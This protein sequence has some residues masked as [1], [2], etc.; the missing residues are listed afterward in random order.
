M[1]YNDYNFFSGHYQSGGFDFG[2]NAVDRIFG[3]IN[4]TINGVKDVISNIT[5]DGSRRNN[6]GYGYGYNPYQNQY[7]YPYQGYG[8]QQN[9]NG[10]VGYGWGDIPASAF[11]NNA[12]TYGGYPGIWNTMY[13]NGGNIR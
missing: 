2:P 4:S 5:D 13:G 1:N 7:S 6:Q 11:M 9:P 8:Y 10:Y 12:P 3:N